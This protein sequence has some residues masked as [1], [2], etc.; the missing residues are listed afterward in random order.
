[1]HEVLVQLL[2]LALE[3][4]LSGGIDFSVGHHQERR[5]VPWGRGAQLTIAGLPAVVLGL[6]SSV[7]VHHRVLPSPHRPGLSLILVPLVLASVM[8]AWGSAT[9]AA[10]R[11]KRSYL[12]TWYGGAV[13]GLGLAAGRLFGLTQF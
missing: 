2:W 9:G 3:I 13:M 7:A 1:M 5:D 12:A 10:R 6:L 4:L 11:P 8:H